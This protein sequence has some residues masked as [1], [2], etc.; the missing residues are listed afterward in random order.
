MT[1]CDGEMKRNENSYKYMNSV[2]VC[3]F[4][5]GFDLPPFKVHFPWSKWL[6]VSSLPLHYMW[7]KCKI[8]IIMFYATTR[9]NRICICA[10]HNLHM[11]LHTKKKKEN[12]FILAAFLKLAMQNTTSSNYIYEEGCRNASHTTTFIRKKGW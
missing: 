2:R 10:L 8:I 4:G 1:I 7:L 9:L 12:N 6:S 5:F 3:R 11:C